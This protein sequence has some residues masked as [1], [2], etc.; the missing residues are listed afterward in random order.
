MSARQLQKAD[1]LAIHETAITMF[2]GLR[3]LRDEGM[4]DSALAQPHQ[5]FGGIELYPTVEE[6]ASRYAYGICQNHP[7][8]DG[9]KRVATACLGVYLRL[10]GLRFKPSHDSLV[11]IM[12]GVASG[13]VSYEELLDWVRSETATT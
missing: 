2:G 11:K 6:K 1:V 5:T 13:V 4:L 8:L 9:N 7:F 3:G 12:L 10:E